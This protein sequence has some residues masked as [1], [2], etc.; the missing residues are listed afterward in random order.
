MNTELLARALSD[1]WLLAT[2]PMVVLSA[3]VLLALLVDVMPAPR[4]LRG[5]IVFGGLAGSLIAAAAL[6]TAP[7]EPGAVLGGAYLANRFIGAWDFLFAAG[8]LIA[9]LFARRYYQDE[10]PFLLEHDALVLCSVIGMMIM[11]GAQDLLTFFI[12]LELLSV[13]LYSLVA[14]RRARNDSVEAGLRYFM[15]GAFM[16]AVYLFGA[17]L[18][19]TTTGSLRLDELA[20]LAGNPTALALVGSAFVLAGLLFKVGAFPFHFWV[21][22]VYQ[23]A[24]TPIT[25]FMAT[26]TKA[27]AI[28]FLLSASRAL[29]AEAGTTL[30]WLAVVTLA[31]GNLG[32]LVQTNLKR[33]LGYSGVAHAGTL[34]LVV[35]GALAGDPVE[36]GPT[37]AVLFYVAAYLFTAGGALG[38]IAMLE[39]SGERFTRLDSLRGLAR[40]RPAVAAAMTLF[41]LSLGGIP[42]TGGFLGK[43]F[44]FSVAVR[45]ELYVPAILGVLTSVVALGYY[46]RVV[47]AMYMEPAPEGELPPTARPLPSIVTV[48]A[49]AALVL[50]LGLA[51][52]LLLSQ[53]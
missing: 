4:A 21:P 28:A 5:T 6:W 12:G 25:A 32:A 29:P 43:W 49:C 31:V 37:Q 50:A 45:A 35:A 11:A 26:G 42:A 53:L 39:Q 20:H 34:L 8:G 13:P 47:V 16:A 30:A 17:G 1:D 19:Y 15:L 18:L 10:R 46:L 7:T 33:L 23:G 44:A 24:P 38:L 48:A 52:G 36:G 27:A 3:A 51:P 14:F 41:M 22:D 40:T 2:G 9:L